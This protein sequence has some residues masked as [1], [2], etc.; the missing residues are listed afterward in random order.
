[1]TGVQTCALTIYDAPVLD[2]QRRQRFRKSISFGY[3]EDNG[4]LVLEVK[5]SKLVYRD[6]AV[7]SEFNKV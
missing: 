2:S 4:I 7:I 5:D 1:M 3:V 6:D